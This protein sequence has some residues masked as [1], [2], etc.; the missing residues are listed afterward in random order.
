MSKILY[1]IQ[2]HK[3][4][5]DLMRALHYH[6]ASGKIEQAVSLHLAEVRALASEVD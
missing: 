6:D 4:D 5:E 1:E 3:N 2:N